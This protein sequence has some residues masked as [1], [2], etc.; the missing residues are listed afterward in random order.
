[1]ATRMGAEPDCSKLTRNR[2]V[3]GGA[4]DRVDGREVL[5]AAAVMNI[6]G[7]EGA[8]DAVVVLRL[9]PEGKDACVWPNATRTLLTRMRS[10]IIPRIAFANAVTK[11]LAK[12]T[13]IW[14]AR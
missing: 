6:D 12:E 8:E 4:Q 9:V 3:G 13:P 14:V 1:M 7:C 2:L 11:H 10:T 5:F